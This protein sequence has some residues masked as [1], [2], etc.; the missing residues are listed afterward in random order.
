[1][2][3]FNQKYK[4]IKAIGQGAFGKIFLVENRYK[5]Y[6][7]VVKVVD[8]SKLREEEKSFVLNEIGIMEKLRHPYV[9]RMYDHLILNN[10]MAI[11]MQYAE[12]R[13]ETK[14]KV[15]T[16]RTRSRRGRE[17]YFRRSYTSSG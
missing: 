16:S 3:K 8:T 7:A 10:S 5:E 13:L 14:Y 12:G 15:E 17:S 6:L 9:V 4:K 2:D 11:V 1:M